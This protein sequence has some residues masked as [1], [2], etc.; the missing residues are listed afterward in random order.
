[1][2]EKSKT[3]TDVE[4]NASD[5]VNPK[6]EP[7]HSDT[8]EIAD[9]APSGIDTADEAVPEADADTPAEPQDDAGSADADLPADESEEAPADREDSSESADLDDAD[10]STDDGADEATDLPTE[11]ADDAAADLTRP[12]PQP[13]PQPEPKIVE[14][15]VE[16][17]R[18]G[19]VP[20]LLGGV[21]AA[22]IGFV[23]GQ[24]GWLD[25]YLPASPQSGASAEAVEALKSELAAQADRIAAAEANAPAP[26]DL[27]PLT[28]RLDAL[29]QGDAG[30]LRSDVQTA[31]QD[32][33]STLAELTDRLTALEKRPLGQDISETAVAAYEREMETLTA[34]ISTLR[35]EVEALLADAKSMEATARA[36]Q[37]AASKAAADAERSGAIARLRQVA[38]T[39]AP[40]AAEAAALAD[41][42][43]VVPDAVTAA[44]ETGIP[45]IATLA[46][47]FPDAARTALAAA[48]DETA[49]A[50]GLGAYINRQL[51][52]RSVAPRDGDDADAILSRA[53]AAVTSGNIAAA[54][55]TLQ[56][57]PDTAKTEL[58]AW[59][60]LASARLS[61]LTAIDALDP[62]QTAN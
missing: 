12:E 25:Q 32:Y 52:A 11:E 45:S 16:T 7:A 39:G 22:G 50:G 61:V 14:R 38:E 37:E 29:E 23:A 57:L 31:L 36:Q 54:L 51:G 13:A 62:S 46:Q 4:A 15:V 5:P 42:G 56:A 1:M 24:G 48:R 8:A 41:L 9:Q 35:S 55:D 44:A 40:F 34:S 53:E 21:V 6:P 19:F 17:K 59:I 18:G 2:S 3:E 30:T 10:D 33:G 28:A 20:A 27:A 43:A 58:A 49:G 47:G 26:V 60:E